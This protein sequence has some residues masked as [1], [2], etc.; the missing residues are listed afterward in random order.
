MLKNEFLHL[1]QYTITSPTVTSQNS[2]LIII[3]YVARNLASCESLTCSYHD[4]D[5]VMLERLSWG[6]LLA[7]RFRFHRDF[8]TAGDFFVAVSM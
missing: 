4:V 2:Q 1:Q 7:S 8:A 3:K 6:F 5:G